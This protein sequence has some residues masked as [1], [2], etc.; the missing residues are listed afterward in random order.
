MFNIS[1]LSLGIT[2]NSRNIDDF[3]KLLKRGGISFPDKL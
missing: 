3:L 2:E 1:N